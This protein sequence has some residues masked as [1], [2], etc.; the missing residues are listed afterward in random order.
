MSSSRVRPGGHA[1]GPG[2]WPGPDRYVKGAKLRYGVAQDATVLA[3]L[4]DTFG[5]AL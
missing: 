4:E 5:L 3:A 2:F 1:K